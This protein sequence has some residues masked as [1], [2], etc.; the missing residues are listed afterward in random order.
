MNYLVNNQQTYNFLADQYEQK[1]IKREQLN[2][3]VISRF[4]RQ[5]TT[6][7][8]VL[9]L[10]C[11][12]GL[13][14]N[15]FISKGFSVTA[16]DISEKMINLAKKRNKDSEIIFGDFMKTQFNKEFDAIFAQAFIHLFP[17]SQAILILQRIKCLLKK[18]GV[19][20][21]TTTKS[22]ESKEGWY[23]K[24]DYSGNHKRYRKYWT[25]EELEE[26]LIQT[27]FGIVDYYK[28]KCS[29][30]KEWMVFAVKKI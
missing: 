11:A 24:S 14:T 5:I 17:K 18:N 10:G 9:D 7:K 21:I 25:K 19:A 2:K 15:I 3:S 6:G 4:I 23:I 13:D 20:H 8:S 12:V 27:G 22:K 28:I 29:F 16:I 26:A 30:N 1:V